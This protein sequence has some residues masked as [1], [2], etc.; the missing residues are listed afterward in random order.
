MTTAE[1]PAVTP[2]TGTPTTPA[3][4]VGDYLDQRLGIAGAA[5]KNLRKIFP[6]HWSFMQIGRAHV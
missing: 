4:K 3:G 2:Y 1:N 6:D 5:K